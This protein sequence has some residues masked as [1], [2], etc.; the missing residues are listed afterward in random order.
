MIPKDAERRM[1][2][3]GCV[4]FKESTQARAKMNKETNK[5]LFSTRPFERK[6]VFATEM[7]LA[8]IMPTT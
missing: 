7:A 4:F 6:T 8:P 1:M 2:M 3:I 5:P